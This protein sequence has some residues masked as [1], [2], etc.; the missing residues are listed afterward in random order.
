MDKFLEEILNTVAPSGYEYQMQNVVKEYTKDFALVSIDHAHNVYSVINEAN[1]FK[2]LMCAHSDEIGMVITKINSNGT[3]SLRKVGGIKLPL[4]VGALVTVLHDGALVNGVIGI[5][6]GVFDGKVTENSLFLDLGVDT[7]EEANKLVSIG[8]ELVV[9]SKTV[10]LN[11]RIVSRALDDKIG[12]YVITKALEELSKRELNSQVCSCTTTREEVGAQGAYVASVNYKPNIA[13]AVDVTYTSDVTGNPS[14]YG[15]VCLG[16]GPAI[17]NSSIIHK[18][19]NSLL[20]NVATK[21]DIP[22]Q[23]EVM[24]RGTGTDADKIH[25]T[26][27]GVP[28]CLVSIPLRYMH[29][30]VE[31]VDKNDLIML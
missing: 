19:L 12:C 30:S 26:N 8:D 17:C 1:D 24:I 2:V 27:E 23:Y 18:K 21:F 10:E 5:K 9:N 3:C 31:M 7:F 25:F 13:I 16:K 11:D 4:Y 28:V 20:T 15:Y 22:V 6:E 29:S 14:D